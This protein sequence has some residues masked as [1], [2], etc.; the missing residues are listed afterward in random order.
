MQNDAFG[1]TDW[2]EIKF[3]TD[4]RFELVITNTSLDERKPSI[5]DEGLQAVLFRKVKVIFSSQ[6]I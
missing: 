3:L 1:F 5:N 6:N 2:P 4:S